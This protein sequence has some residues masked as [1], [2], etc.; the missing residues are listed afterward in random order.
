M[1]KVCVLDGNKSL[2]KSKFCHPM[3]CQSE[4]MQ[5]LTILVENVDA[6]LQRVVERLQEVDARLVAIE[7][8]LDL[9]DDASTNSDASSQRCLDE[10]ISPAPSKVEPSKGKL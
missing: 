9:C 6:T 7:D 10:F 5:A 1:R 4:F 8:A 3:S 2:E